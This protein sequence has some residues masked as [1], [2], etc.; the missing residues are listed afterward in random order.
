LDKL[1]YQDF[2]KSVI[3]VY[4]TVLKKNICHKGTKMQNATK[5]KAIVT[6]IEW[7]VDGNTGGVE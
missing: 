1:I 3:L 6:P 5:E 4:G 7:N 2:N